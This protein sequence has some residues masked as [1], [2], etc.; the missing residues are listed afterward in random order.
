MQEILNQLY[1]Y[2]WGVWRFRWVGLACA[3][4]LSI[5]GWAFVYKL[6]DAYVA[7]A[8]IYVDSNTVLAPLLKGLAIQP[9][10]TQRIQLMSRTLLS[11]PN[12]EK[13]MRM[14]DLDLQVRSDSQNEAFLESLRERISLTGERGNASLYSVRYQDRDRD[15]AKRIV[16]A[17]ITVFIESTLGDKR[18]DSSSAQS[19]L[20]QQIADYEQRLIE[21]ESRL[22]DFKQRY[23]GTLPGEQGDY[24][25]RLQAEKISLR[26]AQL[27]LDEMEN[28]RN[29]LRR[30]LEGEEPVMLSDY[31][32]GSGYSSPLD[33][34]IQ[35]LQVSL[36]SLLAKYTEKHPEVR[37]LRSLIESLEEERDEQFDAAMA[38]EPTSYPGLGNSPLYEGMRTML[39]ET[40]GEVASLQTRVEEYTRRVQE[41]ADKVNN[42][43][44]IETE[45]TQ[46][47][48]D[49]SVIQQQHS[50]LLARREAAMISQRVEQN[51]NDVTFRVVDPPF[52]PIAPNEP[53]KILLNAAVLFAALGA[54]IGLALLLSILRPVISNQYTLGQLTGL[55]YLGGITAIRTAQ[56]KRRGLINRVVFF[57]MMGLLGMSF[58]GVIFLPGILVSA[59]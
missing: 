38:G 35:A 27:E 3:W 39:A 18:E 52:V 43:P 26:D 11:R 4:T 46:L 34:R 59:A 22:A 23:V 30:Q 41:L 10:I 57:S 15:T 5:A 21:A 45:L 14:A 29:E 7:T 12:L 13:M 2:F 47:T 53:N 20:D 19:F 40:E 36:D 51:A 8:R 49:Y 32:A 50:T 42:I 28:R 33:G 44:V 6:P 54:G 58:A 9:N 1:S 16:Q 56:E 55:P 37:Q 48:R 31:V 24:Y 25:A 17:L